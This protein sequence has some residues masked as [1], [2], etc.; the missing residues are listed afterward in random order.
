M[1]TFLNFVNLQARK[2]AAIT[3][4]FTLSVFLLSPSLRAQNCST[5]YPIEEGVRLEYKLYGKKDKLEGTQ[6]QEFTEVTSTAG[7][8][9]ATVQMGF[10][11]AKGK[12][13]FTSSYSMSCN[14]NVVHIDFESL[15]SS[16]MLLQQEQMEAEITGTD[17]ELPNN[18][19]V[20]MELPDADV[21]MKLNMGAMNMNM[22]VNTTDRKV[23]A[24]ESIT[25]EAGTFDCYVISSNTQS[26]MMMADKT[27]PSKLWLAEGV[28]MVKTETYNQ[29]GKLISRMELSGISR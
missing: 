1:K 21:Q 24:R 26:K 25:T 10:A 22:E 12:E 8:V 20:G 19:E 14:D 5:Y 15:L 9:E 18:L 29:N 7:G 2:P 3:A 23:E 13:E 17:L 4:I 16:A 27:F 11:N 28:G 6:W